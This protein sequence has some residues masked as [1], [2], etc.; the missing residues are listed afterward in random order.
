MYT[1]GI[2]MYVH[3]P[4]E[5][6]EGSVSMKAMTDIILPSDNNADNRLRGIQRRRDV[7]AMRSRLIN[8]R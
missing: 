5:R 7:V 4:G 3:L 2:C 1:R 6:T 8:S